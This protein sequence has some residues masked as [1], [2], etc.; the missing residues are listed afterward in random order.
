MTQSLAT[1]SSEYQAVIRLDGLKD[2]NLRP[3]RRIHTAS[4]VIGASAWLRDQS[5]LRSKIS[6]A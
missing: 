3:R 2:F 4:F 1:V 6:L 5:A